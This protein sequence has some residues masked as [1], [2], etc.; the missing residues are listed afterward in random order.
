[1]PACWRMTSEKFYIYRKSV[2]L[3]NCKIFI[4][5]RSRI[6]FYSVSGTFRAPVISEQKWLWWEHLVIVSESPL[7]R[8]RG[9]SS[10]GLP[11]ERNCEE[12][13][14]RFCLAFRTDFRENPSTLS[15][16]G[17]VVAAED[18]ALEKEN[19]VYKTTHQSPNNKCISMCI[20]Q[21]FEKKKQLI[22]HQNDTCIS[23]VCVK[24]YP[25]N[26]WGL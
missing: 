6:I 11:W 15:T 3:F 9:V 13:W 12:L 22:L 26:N 7:S 1:M 23:V 25:I 2:F 20:L 24:I 4:D 17:G 16:D 19:E 14:E 8:G 18:I 10:I 21:I 5:H